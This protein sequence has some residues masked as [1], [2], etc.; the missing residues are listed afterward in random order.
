[1]AEAIYQALETTVARAGASTTTSPGR[2][3]D[4]N[5]EAAT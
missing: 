5:L 2:K 1:L 4:K 3:R